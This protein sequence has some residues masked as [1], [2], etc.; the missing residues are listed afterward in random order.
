LHPDFRRALTTTPLKGGL[1]N[2]SQG[3][4]CILL[5]D[6]FYE[7]RNLLLIRLTTPVLEGTNTAL[8]CDS[9]SLNILGVIRNFSTIGRK[10]GL[11]IQY[12]KKLEVEHLDNTLSILKKNYKLTGRPL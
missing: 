7:K 11:H 9:L 6:K 10:H 2:I 1:R 3:G 8:N 4:I 12:L 5:D